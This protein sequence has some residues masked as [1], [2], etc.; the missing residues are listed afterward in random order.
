MPV[1]FHSSS[2]DE[3]V[4]GWEEA[5]QFVVLGQGRVVACAP[6]ALHQGTILRQ[7]G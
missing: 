6:Q 1:V 2:F 3:G 5:D 4:M 7:A